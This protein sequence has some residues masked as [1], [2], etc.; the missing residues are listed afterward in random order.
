GEAL[1][2]RFDSGGEATQ[3]AGTIVPGGACAN[4]VAIA[5]GLGAKTALIA[6]TAIDEPAE[7]LRQALQRAGGD[8]S[9]LVTGPAAVTRMARILVD[10]S[11]ERRFMGFTPNDRSADMRLRRHHIKDDWFD[12]PSIFHFSSFL[13]AEELSALAVSLALG[14]A[15][16]KNM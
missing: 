5:A 6:C 13:D 8:T 2:D 3:E 16:K 12:G 4:V 15:R 10:P 9:G 7:I 11:G 14:N 1:T